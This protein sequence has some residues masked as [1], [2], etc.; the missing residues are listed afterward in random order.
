MLNSNKTDYTE[1]K[2]KVFEQGKKLIEKLKEDEDKE[3]INKRNRNSKNRKRGNSNGKHKFDESY[4][5]K[6]LIIDLSNK[7]C[8]KCVS[9][10]IPLNI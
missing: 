8:P 3:V 4:P 1:E 7:E 2:Q 10:L 5:R 9:K 6:E